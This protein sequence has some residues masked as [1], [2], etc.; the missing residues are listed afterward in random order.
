MIQV[1]RWKPLIRYPLPAKA[2]NT[3]MTVTT[4]SIRMVLKTIFLLSSYE[5][6]MT[7]FLNRLDEIKHQEYKYPNQIHKVPVEANLLDH[8]VLIFT[9]NIQ[10]ADYIQQYDDQEYNT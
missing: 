2:I 9:S 5:C 4:P 10:S 6:P 3:S 8:F 7:Y 1:G